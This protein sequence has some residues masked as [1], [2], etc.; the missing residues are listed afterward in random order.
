MAFSL[1]ALESSKQSFDRFTE[2][3]LKIKGSDD[4][5]GKERVKLY[6]EQFQKAVNDDLNM[7]KALSVVWTVLRDEKL[8]DKHKWLLIENFDDVLGLGVHDYK[9]EKITLTKDIQDLVDK[10]EQLRQAKK[11]DEADKIRDQLTKKGFTLIDTDDD[12]QIKKK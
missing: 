10:R 1:K 5:K 12:V 2:H 3:I 8:G 9:E 7:P 11:F 4:D 6:T